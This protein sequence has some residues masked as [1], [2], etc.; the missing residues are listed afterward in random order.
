[1]TLERFQ[2]PCHT[3]ST[4]PLTHKQVHPCVIPA[5]ARIHQQTRLR[6]LRF[7]KPLLHY[8]CHR[9]WLLLFFS[10]SSTFF[11]R[12]KESIHSKR[13]LKGLSCLII[14]VFNPALLFL[15]RRSWKTFGKNYEG[16]LFLHKK[17]KLFLDHLQPHYHIM[18]QISRKIIPKKKYF[19]NTNQ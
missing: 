8:A 9:Q 13:A 1:M 15:L 11:I 3:T 12:Q 17:E 5:K 10:L 7:L 14:K 16:L 18:L 4:V 6:L 2:T 19:I